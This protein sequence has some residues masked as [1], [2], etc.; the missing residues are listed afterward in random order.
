MFT[1]P[2]RHHYFVAVGMI[3]ALAL[4]GCSATQSASSD[5]SPE[6]T[7]SSSDSPDSI[8]ALLPQRIQDAGKLVIATDAQLPP[9]NFIGP[10]GKTIIGVSIDMGNAI[11]EALGVEAEFINTKFASIIPGL[12][13]ERYDIAMSGITDTLEREKQVD[14]IDFIESG[15]VFIVPS[16]NPGE[17]DSLETLCGKTASLIA[18]TISVDIAT[19][20]SEQCTN[21]N[22]AAVKILTFPTAADA[23]LQLQNGRAD[24]NIANIG[25]A[26]YQ[27]QESGGK[28]EVAGDPFRP[29]YDAVAVPKG[30]TELIA[31]LQAA[32]ESIMA[33]GQ[34]QAVLAKW[35]VE[36]SGMDKTVVNGA[37][38]FEKE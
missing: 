30:D 7:T 13:A 31:A 23:L 27:S 35:E 6:P 24:A 25:K 12:Q 38:A 32:F 17:V 22:K 10:D 26:A 21:D 28:L 36:A 15:Q 5:P 4:A 1:R 3:G 8:G 29:S 33:D 2:S 18:G 34:Y 9:N 11:A 16:G 14:F 20:A 19:E 37:K